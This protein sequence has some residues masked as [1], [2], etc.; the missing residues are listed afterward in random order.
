ML[1]GASVCSFSGTTLTAAASGSCTVEVSIA[2]DGFY[3]AATSTNLVTI[4]VGG[5]S[6]TI[7]VATSDSSITV[8]DAARLT[9]TASAGIG[10]KTYSVLIGSSACCLAGATLSGT[11]AGSC[12]VA[13]FLA[14]NCH[15]DSGE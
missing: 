9:S 2:T 7:T 1:T 14:R 8:G 10:A 6:H 3:S 5:A 15:D 12:T 13:E 4:S 11:A